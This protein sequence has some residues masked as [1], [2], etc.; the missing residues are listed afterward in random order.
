MFLSTV[1]D[2]YFVIC[3]IVGF[4][5][6]SMSDFLKSEGQTGGLHPERYTLPKN[7]SEIWG[8]DLWFYLTKVA[9]ATPG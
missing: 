8:R 2:H 3:C 5:I 9:D 4:H 7:N 6:M 1:Y